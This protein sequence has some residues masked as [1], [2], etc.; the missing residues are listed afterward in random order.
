M[1]PEFSK[2]QRLEQD[3]LLTAIMAETPPMNRETVERLSR[4]YPGRRAEIL[5]WAL[6]GW[7]DSRESEEAERTQEQDA[8]ATKRAEHR[9]RQYLASCQSSLESLAGAAR[10]RG[11]EPAQVTADL[12]IGSSVFW[13]LERRLIGAATIPAAFMDKVA[14]LLAVPR[15]AV[16]GYL[17][18]PPTL[19]HGASFYANEPPKAARTESWTEAIE[20]AP[21]MSVEQKKPWLTEEILPQDE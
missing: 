1:E 4:R 10:E 19:S 7:M 20:A 17:R 15:A 16:E 13:K 12:A 8:A 2:Q 18:M 3:D 9:L 21:D 5:D 11:I 14:A 6:A